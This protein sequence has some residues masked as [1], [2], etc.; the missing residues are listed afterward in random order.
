PLPASRS[1]P[2]AR[3]PARLPAAAARHS[4]VAGQRVPDDSPDL[5]GAPAGP[6]SRTGPVPLTRQ[7][8]LEGFPPSSSVDNDAPPPAAPRSRQETRPVRHPHSFRSCPFLPMSPCHPVR[9]HGSGAECLPQPADTV[10]AVDLQAAQIGDGVLLVHP[11]LE[12]FLF[13]VEDIQQ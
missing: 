4:P 12:N 11:G 10:Q 9:Q 7:P 6:A 5:S 1:P 8:E 2:P 13:G 3:R